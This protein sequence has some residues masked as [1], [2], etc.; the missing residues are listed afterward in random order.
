MSLRTDMQIISEWITR[1][2]R[3]LDLGCGDG[4]LLRHLMDTSGVN[5]YGLEIDKQNIAQSIGQGINVIQ[6]DIDQGL[7]EYFDDDS[8]DYVTLTQTLQATYYP[9]RLLNEML[10][11]GREGIVTFPNFGHWRSRLQLALGGRMPVTPALPSEWY[12]TRNIHLCTLL[13]FEELCRRLD[14]EILQRT[15]VDHA[16]RSS[17]GMKLAPNWLGEI[18]IYRFRRKSG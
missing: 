4:T 6:A 7:A 2:S 17:L 14:I 8:F 9:D 13:D 1:G 3:V 12:N 15:V 10:R 11:V 18:A 5:G 16:H